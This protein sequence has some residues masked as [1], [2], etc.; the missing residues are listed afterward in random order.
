MS[1]NEFE[2]MQ[3]RSPAEGAEEEQ[4]FE[5]T[6]DGQTFVITKDELLRGYMRQADYTKKTMHLA[7]MRKELESAYLS[8]AEIENQIPNTGFDSVINP[9]PPPASN[10]DDDRVS[11][12]EVDLAMDK[13]ERMVDKI[14]QVDKSFDTRAE[15]AVLSYMQKHNLPMSQMPTIWKAFKFDIQQRRAAEITTKTQT[16]VPPSQTTQP[17]QPAKQPVKPTE[18]EP[19]VEPSEVSP[20]AVKARLTQGAVPPAKEPAPSVL[21]GKPTPKM[22]IPQPSFSSYDQVT[23]AMISGEIPKEG[24]LVTEGE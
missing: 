3:T 17:S 22:H 4:T 24:S 8:P 23:T 15:F 18:A 21:T 9:N 5:V 16:K 2:I 13:L 14:R 20:N 1:M 12:L 11:R 7:Q 6:V 10:P 19:K